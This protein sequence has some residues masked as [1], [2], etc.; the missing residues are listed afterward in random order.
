MTKWLFSLYQ[1]DVD[2]RLKLFIKSIKKYGMVYVLWPCL[3]VIEQVQM[4][5]Q[6]VATSYI[7]ES[8]CK[9]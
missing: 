9:Q 7:K 6:G 4:L 3:N 5:N 8:D 1:N 2:T